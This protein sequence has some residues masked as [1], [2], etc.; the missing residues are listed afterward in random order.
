MIDSP[1]KTLITTVDAL[2]DLNGKNPAERKPATAT[3]AAIEVGT[4]LHLDLDLLDDNPF[5]P[6]QTIDDAAIRELMA[7][8]EAHGL[9][10]AI[11]VRRVG[12]RYQIIAGHRRVTAFRRLREKDSARFGRIPAQWRKEVSDQEM[13]VFALVE[14]LQRADLSPLE[15]AQ[16][17]AAFQEREKLS[18]GQLATKT[19]LDVERVKRLL[20]LYR[21]PVV[22]KEACH[23]GVLV[24]I[25][26]ERG[27][28][29]VTASGE[30]K[31]QRRKLDLL[32]ALEF[33][34]LHA[35]IAER[36]PQ[37]ADVRTKTAVHRALSEGWGL[38]RIQEHVQTTIRGKA[39]NAAA[40]RP[41]AVFTQDG[42]TVRI[43]PDR[44]EAASED[45]RAGLRELLEGLLAKVQVP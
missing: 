5:Q 11:T 27:E 24:P 30:P 6:R 1:E 42:G 22:V 28:L 40:P 43:W 38:R 26:D 3:H 19:G 34:K 44:I 4:T 35:F 10:Q 16:G 23:S 45:E 14:N 31:Q 37:A 29:V 36:K 17:L 20:R 33:A 12:Q 32:A 7:S 9:L 2:L 25:R 18:T 15:A 41:L 13:A 39:E 21:A 8:I